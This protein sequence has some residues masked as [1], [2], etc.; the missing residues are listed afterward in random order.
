MSSDLTCNSATVP[1]R[2]S[3]LPHSAPLGL[4]F[5]DPANASL[6]EYL[7]HS[8]FVTYHGPT[9]HKL[10]LAPFKRGDVAAPPSSAQG[11][12]DFV[13]TDKSVN[14]TNCISERVKGPTATKCIAP[15]GLT[16]D[17]SG[18][19]FWTSDQTGEVFAVTRNKT[20]EVY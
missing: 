4:R 18:T 15:V 19:L 3:I 9:G 12:E 14:L 8:A 5:Y 7:R 16:Y 2:L 11:V 17:E 6:G 20:Q 13:W 10:V 1:P